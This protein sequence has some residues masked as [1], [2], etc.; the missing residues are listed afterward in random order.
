MEEVNR[1]NKG[2]NETLEDLVRKNFETEIQ[3]NIKSA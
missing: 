2:L 1:K 3:L